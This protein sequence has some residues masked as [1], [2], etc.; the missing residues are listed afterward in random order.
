[1]ANDRRAFLRTAAAGGAAA[2]LGAPFKI[3]AEAIGRWDDVVDVVI[4]GSGAAAM[5]A[6][7]KARALG[8]RVAVL[9]KSTIPGGTTA[10]SEGGV[11]APNNRFLREAGIVDSR[12]DAIR[13]MVRLSFSDR[14]DPNAERFGAPEHDYRLIAA[15]YD[16]ASRVL[17]ELEADGLRLTNTFPGG[18]LI[19]D[20]FA[21]LP[22]SNVRQGRAVVPLK[23]DGSLGKGSDLIR[24]L[25]QGLRARGGDVMTGHRVIGLVQDEAGRVVGVRAGLADDSTRLIGARKAVIF[26]TG[27]FTHNP[28]MCRDYLKGPTYGGCAAAAAEGDFVPMATAAGATLGNMAN[29]WWAQIVLEEALA[30]SS[31]STG[32]WATPGDSAIQVNREGRRFVNEK[33]VYSERTQMH[34]QWDPIAGRYPNLVSFMIYDA[35]T[36]EEFAG[37]RGLPPRGTDLPYVIRGSDLKTLTAAL[38]ERLDTLA[39]HIGGLQLSERFLPNL[40]DAIVRFNGA[41]R[42]GVDPEFSRG[43]QPIDHFFHFFGPRQPANPMPNPTMHPFSDTGP[44]YAV[45]MAAGMVDTKGGPKTDH[46]ARVL[47]TNGAP[48]VGLYGAGNCIASPTG[49]AYWGAGATLG[50]ALTFGNIAARHAHGIASATIFA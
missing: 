47:H 11:W 4:V 5:S 45:I 22:E 18:I 2:I 30:I 13:Y 27:G 8:D 41:A 25:Q 9:E 26:G 7:L 1:M 12:D 14:Y 50:P 3:K 10:R 6:A 16:N 24:A 28:I 19:P 35:R 42:A 21:H 23:P 44:Y 46:Y 31:V 29:A 43:A 38:S 34:F 15:F 33:A 36:A 48:I 39:P 17:E 20:Y 37:F 49:P 40:R 32:I